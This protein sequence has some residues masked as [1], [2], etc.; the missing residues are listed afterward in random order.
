[1]ST[2]YFENKGKD[3]TATVFEAVRERAAVLGIGSI[4]VATNE[5]GTPLMAREMMPNMNITAVTHV[6]GFKAPNEQEL[7]DD[8]RRLLEGK[9]IAV[10]TA[11]HSFWGIGKA[12]RNK[13]QMPGTNDII[14]DTLRIFGQ[15]MK[16]CCELALMAADAGIIRVGED[17]ITVGGSARGADTA[18]V[19]T[20]ANT[21]NFFDLKVK[22]IICKPR[23]F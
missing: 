11:S 14:A 1:M 19:L 17:V 12:V 23:N 10:V 5:G 3:N 4:V 9:D 22:E 16:V 8:N 21:H 20:A 18:V 6:T 13:Y 7:S 15:G 2:I